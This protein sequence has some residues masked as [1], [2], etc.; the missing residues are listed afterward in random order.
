MS[1]VFMVM[2]ARITYSAPW[3][4]RPRRNS[5]DFPILSFWWYSAL[6]HEDQIPKHQSAGEVLTYTRGFVPCS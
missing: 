1:G 3:I 4:S 6:S 5:F 2:P